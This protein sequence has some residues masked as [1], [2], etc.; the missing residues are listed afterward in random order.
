MIPFARVRQ[1]LFDEAWPFWADTGLD[2]VHGGPVETLALDGR[3][4]D[5]PFKRVR[6]LCRQV[7]CF[8]HAAVLG[9]QGAQSLTATLFADLAAKAWLGPERGWARRLSPEG[10]VIDA[11]PDL[12]DIAFCLFACGWA[13]RATGEARALALAHATLDFLDARMRWPQGRGYLHADPCEGPRLQNPHMH[14]TEAA[15]AC[16]E[17]SGEARFAERALEGVGLFKTGFFDPAAG[18]LGEYFTADWRRLDSPEGRLVE[19]GHQLEWAWILGRAAALL[20]AEVADLPDRLVGFAEAHGIDPVSGAVFN[21]VRDDG[22]PLDRGSRT[23]PN[24]ERIKGHLA[25]IER[26][27]G[28]DRAAIAQSA[29]LLLDRYLAVIP[30]GTWIDAFD[31]EGRAIAKNIPTSTLYHVQLAFLEL[32]RLEPRLTAA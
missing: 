6:V 4:P 28:G 30:R 14:L 26:G 20:G 18:V 1:W 31:G 9:H 21:A 10:A 24:T 11:A 8:A 12:Y 19:P 23:W 32:L 15:I 29:A 5:S 16:F 13:Y 2:R 17:A 25:L 7:Y 3:T 27:S 22:A